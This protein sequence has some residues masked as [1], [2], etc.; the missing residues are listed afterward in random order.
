MLA[1]GVVPGKREVQLIEH[2]VPQMSG[3]YDVKIRALDVGICGTDKEICTFVY[4]SPPD[5]SDYLVLGHESL[6]QV[7][8]VGAGVSILKPGDLVVPSV[9]IPCVHPHCKPCQADLQ[10]F[11][12]T[13]DFSERGIKMNHGYMTEFYVE[14]EKYLNLVPT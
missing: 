10:D 3:A 11:C 1:V 13:G 6:G 12:S 5:G 4:G 2:P 9:R 7:M 14:Q 8:E